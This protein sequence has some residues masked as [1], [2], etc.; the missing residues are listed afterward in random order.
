MSSRT[1]FRTLRAG[2]VIVSALLVLAV[3]FGA[4]A[5]VSIGVGIARQGDSL[6]YGD[7][8]RVP[9]QVSPDHLGS[10]PPEVTPGG[11]PDVSVEVNRPTTK[12][13][14]L[15]SAQDLGPVVL[16]VAG[17]WIIRRFLRS[18]LQDAPFSEL[19]VRRLRSI[20]TL[21]VVGVPIVELLN[22][23][24]RLSLYN[25][26]PPFPTTDLGVAGFT[27]PLGALLAGLGVFMLAEVFAY[28]LS[29]REDV[30]GTI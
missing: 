8:L 12:Q 9:L 22:Y 30:E 21:L 25:D 27:L 7:T 13:M 20:G 15:R 6:L 18:T 19:N 14:V 17:L 16:I 3:G 26:L 1:S 5:V 23:S 11:W 10:L 24:L 4:V 28:G 2:Y 29:L